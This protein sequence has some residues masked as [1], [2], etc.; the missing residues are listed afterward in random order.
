MNLPP[1][2]YNEAVGF[3]YLPNNV[4]YNTQT[5]PIIYPN[6]SNL[7]T[8]IKMKKDAYRQFVNKEDFTHIPFANRQDIKDY[9]KRLGVNLR[10]N[11]RLL[12]YVISFILEGV[13]EG[14]SENLDKNGIIYYTNNT[15][16]EIQWEHPLEEYYKS[17]VKQ[18]LKENSCW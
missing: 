18:V 9:G 2:N 14:W 6:M 3:N 5:N 4:A 13:P 16:K 17:K 12:R 7:Q 8:R 10:K 15:L 1:P 11:P